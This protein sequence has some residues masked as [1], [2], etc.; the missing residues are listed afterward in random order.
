MHPQML[1]KVVFTSRVDGVCLIEVVYC[2]H[3]PWER[4]KKSV[5]TWYDELNQC[6]SLKQSLDHA[7]LTRPCLLPKHSAMSLYFF[8]LTGIK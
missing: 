5:L 2:F 7:A 6:P 8:S 4:Q 3:L 1:G